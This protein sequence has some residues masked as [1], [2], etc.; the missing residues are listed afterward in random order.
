MNDVEKI[1]MKELNAAYFCE[2]NFFVNVY[3][4]MTDAEENTIDNKRAHSSVFSSSVSHPRSRNVCSGG[5]V[6]ITQYRSASPNGRR[7]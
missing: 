5:F 4:A 6:S 3:S 1:N 7:L 2:R